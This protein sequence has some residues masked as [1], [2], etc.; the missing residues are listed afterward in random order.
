M[1]PAF[2][3]I[4]K[5]WCMLLFRWDESFAIWKTNYN[6]NSGLS[7]DCRITRSLLSAHS[8]AHNKLSCAIRRPRAVGGCLCVWL[9]FIGGPHVWRVLISSLTSTRTPSA[10][11]PYCSFRRVMSV[12]SVHTDVICILLTPHREAAFCGWTHQANVNG[13]ALC[14]CVC[15]ALH[16]L[17]YSICIRVCYC[18]FSVHMLNHSRNNSVIMCVS[19]CKMWVFAC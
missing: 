12:C 6:Y 1:L 8:E 14:V 18:V 9:A 17:N 16:L 3:D 13:S 10:W 7:V 5:S 15:V 19:V 4:L 2:E 11:S